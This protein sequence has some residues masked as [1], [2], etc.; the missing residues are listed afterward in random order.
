M[1]HFIVLQTFVLIIV[2]GNIMHTTEVFKND[3]TPCVLRQIVVEIRISK[4]YEEEVI[5]TES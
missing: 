1:I 5:D 3:R 4:E 2:F